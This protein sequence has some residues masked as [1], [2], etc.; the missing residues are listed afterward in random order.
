MIIKHQ[1]SDSKMP[2]TIS[3]NQPDQTKPNQNIQSKTIAP[4]ILATQE[5]SDSSPWQPY[6]AKGGPQEGLK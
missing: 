3:I 5:K 1:S 6:L 4:P 2:L